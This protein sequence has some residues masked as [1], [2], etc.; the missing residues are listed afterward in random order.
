MST[1]FAERAFTEPVQALQTRAGSR[2][3][4]ARQAAIHPGDG[5]RLGPDEAAFIAARDSC[6]VATVGAGGWPYI[7]HRGGPPG[8]LRVLD[9][10]TLGLADLRGNRQYVTLGNLAT[11]DRIAMIL[12]DYPAR[13]RLKLL[14][15]VRVIEVGERPWL[16]E[17]GLAAPDARIERG[18]EIAVEA[19]DWNCPQHITPRFTLPEIDEAVAPLRAR[20]AALEAELARR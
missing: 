4:Y 5:S 2:A 11:D 12:V 17:P 20:I 7:Q 13:A 1:A 16:A 6:Y 8:F 15:R 9:D 14:G 19:F 18:L 10:H 3:A